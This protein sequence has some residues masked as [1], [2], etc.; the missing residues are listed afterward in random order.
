MHFFQY[1]D[2]IDMAVKMF[3]G[4]VNLLFSIEQYFALFSN[5]L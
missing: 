4:K 2:W 1:H 3:K 5:I